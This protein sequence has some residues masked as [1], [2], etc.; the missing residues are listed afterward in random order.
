MIKINTG[1]AAERGIAHGDYVELFNDRGRAVM[2]AIVTESVAPGV[3]SYP[4]GWQSAQYKAG[5]VSE[6]T[7]S[8]YDPVAVNSNYFDTLVEV[9]LWKDGE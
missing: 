2:K 7:N 6:L 8:A 9:R 3:L 5:N 4:K 1:D